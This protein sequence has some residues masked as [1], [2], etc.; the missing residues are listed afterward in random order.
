[1]MSFKKSKGAGYDSL[2]ETKGLEEAEAESFVF[3]CPCCEV[4]TPITASQYRGL[5]AI[6]CPTVGCG[7]AKTVNVGA[8]VKGAGGR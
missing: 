6:D 8:I 4:S 3:M 5:E 7:F 2:E 1:M